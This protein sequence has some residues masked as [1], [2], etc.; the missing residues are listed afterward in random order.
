MQDWVDSVCATATYSYLDGKTAAMVEHDKQEALNI[1]YENFKEPLAMYRFVDEIRDIH[2]GKH[3]RWIRKGTNTLTNGGI[4]LQV[5]FL[6]K[7]TYLLCKNGNR[8]MQYLF[9]DCITF[10]KVTT[11]EWIVLNS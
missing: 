2:M 11:E 1:L 9:D 3:I 6:A 8:M 4:A 5:K 7:G 10:Q